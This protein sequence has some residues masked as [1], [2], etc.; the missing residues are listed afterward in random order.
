VNPASAGMRHQGARQ[1][2]KFL[3]K[4]RKALLCAVARI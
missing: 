4:R 3:L 2:A 1:L